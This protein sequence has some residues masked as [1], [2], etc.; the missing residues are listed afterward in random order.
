MIMRGEGGKNRICRL[1]LKDSQKQKRERLGGGGLAHCTEKKRDEKGGAGFGEI[2][3]SPASKSEEKN[4]GT[5]FRGRIPTEKKRGEGGGCPFAFPKGDTASEEGFP[6]GEGPTSER[7]GE[8]PWDGRKNCDLG[9]AEECL[10]KPNPERKKKKKMKTRGE[11]GVWEGE[12]F[13]GGH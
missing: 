5:L 10:K 2:M 7:G 13:L 9:V 1:N 11:K 12:C 4:I 6:G 3:G 8:A